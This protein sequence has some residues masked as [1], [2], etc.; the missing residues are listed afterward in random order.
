MNVQSIKEARSFYAL[1]CITSPGGKHRGLAGS[2]AVLI[3]ES[4]LMLDAV[5]TETVVGIV[6]ST[7]TLQ[8][9]IYIS[10][11][12]RKSHEVLDYRFD[13]AVLFCAIPSTCICRDCVNRNGDCLKGIDPQLAGVPAS[14]IT[15]SLSACVKPQVTQISGGSNV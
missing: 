3:A 6:P 7:Q 4:L 2:V 8:H 9:P 5:Y 11:P 14:L 13:G 1:T 15:E 10:P 12:W